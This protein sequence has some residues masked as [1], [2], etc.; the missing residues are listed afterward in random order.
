MRNLKDSCLFGEELV[1]YMYDELP[2]AKRYAFESHLLNCS[3][4]TNEFA[5]LS[6]SRLAV[7]EWNRDDFLPLETPRF[8]IPYATPEPAC[9]WIDA[10]RRF[11]TPV[12]LSFAGGGLALMVIAAGLFY[13]ANSNSGEIANDVQI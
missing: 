12:R 8:A 3:S 7:Y 6:V 11:L 1:S 4:C 5:E 9:S 2:A 13:V 10:I